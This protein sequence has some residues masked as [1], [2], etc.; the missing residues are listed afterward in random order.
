MVHLSN[1]F[2]ACRMERVGG[3]IWGELKLNASAG[4][5]VQLPYFRSSQVIRCI[6]QPL[7]ARTPYAHWSHCRRAEKFIV[8]LKFICILSCVQVFDVA[9]EWCNYKYVVCV[10]FVYINYDY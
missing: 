5:V 2:F 9:L 7:R 8:A 3:N 1:G 6:L 10:V 4:A